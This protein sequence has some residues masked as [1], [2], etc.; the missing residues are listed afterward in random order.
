MIALAME[1]WGLHRRIALVIIRAIGGGPTR[2]VLGF[3][4]ERRKQR[5][6]IIHHLL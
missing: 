4:V 5:I 6:S 3:M 1:T 2:I